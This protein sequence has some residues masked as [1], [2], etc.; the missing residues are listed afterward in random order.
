MLGR[1]ELL[2]LCWDGLNPPGRKIL[3]WCG[4]YSLKR[5]PAGLPAPLAGCTDPPDIPA[6]KEAPWQCTEDPQDTDFTNISG[7]RFCFHGSLG[8]GFSTPQLPCFQESPS[9]PLLRFNAAS[10]PKFQA[11]AAPS[12]IILA[13]PTF[14]FPFF[15]LFF[16]RR[17]HWGSP[18][19]CAPCQP[20]VLESWALLELPKENHGF[21]P[22]LLHTENASLTGF[23][24]SGRLKQH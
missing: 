21:F 14:P 24:E 7:F 12:Y 6:L 4:I 19:S 17:S 5:H 10:I 8:V 2:Q 22:R 18:H 13:A 20:S 16:S 9:V 23:T 3:P 15:L 1:K 11:L